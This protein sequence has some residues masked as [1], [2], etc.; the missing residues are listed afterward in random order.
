M[1]G[2]V[3]TDSRDRVAIPARTENPIS[4]TIGSDILGLTLGLHTVERRRGRVQRRQRCGAEA[5]GGTIVAL[6]HAM[7]P[8]VR[9]GGFGAACSC[10]Q[11]LRHLI[12]L[13]RGTETS[14][15]DVVAHLSERR[16]TLYSSG[17]GGIRS[18]LG[19]S[20]MDASA[21]VYL[22]TQVIM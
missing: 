15:D 6:S 13:S 21:T 11:T 20:S 17:T 16:S 12:V 1:A 14:A 4:T 10:F 3:A 9:K 5:V 7:G 18:T 8:H 19:G 2:L 22:L